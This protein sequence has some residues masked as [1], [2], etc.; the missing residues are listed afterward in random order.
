LRTVAPLAL[1][2][3]EGRWHLQGIDQDAHGSRTFLL[4]RI[5]GPVSLTNRGF[6]PDGS[7]FAA[8]ALDE[9]ERIWLG[10][11]AEIEVVAKSDAAIRLNKRYGDRSPSNTHLTVHYTDA[12]ILA[13]EFASYGPE[14]LVLSPDSLR[15]AVRS[16]LDATVASHRDTFAHTEPGARDD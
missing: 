1:V 11:V 8:H 4:S 10:N 14:V 3:H 5:V 15:D 6:E 12:N 7:D 9:L 16:R 13:D 2:Q